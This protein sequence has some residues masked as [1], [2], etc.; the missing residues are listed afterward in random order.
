[1]AKKKKSRFGANVGGNVQRQKAQAKGFGYL[2]LPKGI[3]MFKEK[4]GRSHFDIIPYY[5]TAEKHSDRDPDD[6]TTA[7]VGNP[8]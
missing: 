6:P 1:M 2:N 3:K 5:V 8:W 4:V 7:H